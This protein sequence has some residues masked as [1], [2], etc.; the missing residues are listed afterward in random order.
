MQPMSKYELPGEDV[1]A[2]ELLPVC[3][4]HPR[5]GSPGG[6]R[7]VRQDEPSDGALGAAECTV[8]S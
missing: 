3:G 1:E 5:E 6:L 8:Y 7:R 4:I 2:P